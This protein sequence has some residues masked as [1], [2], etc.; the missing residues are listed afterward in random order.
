METQPNQ[1]EALK[2]RT[3]TFALRII[4]MIR[5]LPRSAEGRIISQQ[6]LR[7][8]MSVAANYRACCRA[9]SRVEFLSKLAIVI[10]EADESA[11]W[12]ELLIDAGFVPQPKLKDLTSEANQLVAIFNASRVTMKKVFHHQST[13]TNQQWIHERPHDQSNCHLD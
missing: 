12:L 5:S 4:R 2:V 13:I 9:R 11:F 10:E 8:G 6:L 1:A 7:S 3:K